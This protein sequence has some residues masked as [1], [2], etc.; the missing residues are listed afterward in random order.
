[1]HRYCIL[2]N[3]KSN[4][5]TKYLSSDATDDD[6]R[7]GR[8]QANLFVINIVHSRKSKCLFVIY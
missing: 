5:V 1:M 7:E 6:G 8:L 3:E 2:G 4:A